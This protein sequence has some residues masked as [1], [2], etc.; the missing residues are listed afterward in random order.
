VALGKDKSEKETTMGQFRVVVDAV[1]GHGC[2][3]EA[4]DGE[5]VIG[6]ERV[7]C[8]DC[9]AREFVRRL[10]RS[11]ATVSVARIEHWPTEQQVAPSSGQVTDDLLTG[12]RA[13]K[14]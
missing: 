7:G 5:V 4:G 11:G 8:P 3:R 12:L 14:F 9:I 13:G 10:K 2:M 1:G 6:C